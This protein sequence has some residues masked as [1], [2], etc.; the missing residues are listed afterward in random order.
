M[1]LS[2]KKI[3]IDIEEPKAGI[4]FKSLFK[5]F[6]D[7]K[8]TLMITARDFDSTFQIMDDTGFKYIKVGRHGGDSL[9]GK[10]EAY[11]ERVQDLLPYVTEFNP[12]FFVTFGSVE[13]VRISFGLQI[14]SIG[15][16]DEPRSYHVSKLLFPF[17]DKIITPKCIP[18]EQ[19][20]RLHADPEKIIRMNSLDEIAWLSTYRPNLKNLQEYDIEKGRYVL[21][22][23]EPS[24]ASY[25]VN[26]MKPEE[27]LLAKF[28]PSI[29]EEFSDYK[30]FILVRSEMQ[31]QWLKSQL[32]D[33]AD[34]KNVIITRYLP[35]ITD[36]CFY[37]ALVISG[38]GTI[39]RESSLLNIPSLE[40]FPGETPPQDL[41]LIENGF[42]LEHIKESEEIIKRSIEILKNGPTSSRFNLSYREKI[43]QFENPIDICFNYVEEK[44][45]K[46]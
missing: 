41:F 35:H 18:Q 17:I 32:K 11:S 37:A 14:R 22:R 4:M 38:G 40:F 5:K 3:W 31:E 43:S 23:T 33:Y 30:Y 29:Y 6:E 13:G 27:T 44:L 16:S 25:L 36:L 9:V 8:A 26:Q 21:L 42:S 45:K 34:K 7:E 1:S 2:G 19:Y 24:T 46:Q 12:D 20:E 10:L 28:F 15:F 39:I